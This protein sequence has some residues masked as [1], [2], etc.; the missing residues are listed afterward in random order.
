MGRRNVNDEQKQKMR[1]I[2]G[3]L[4]REPVRARLPECEWHFDARV[5]DEQL[6][7]CCYWEYARESA[8]IRA[9]VQNLNDVRAGKGGGRALDK[10][11]RDL[12]L[13]YSVGTPACLISRPEFP[14]PWLSL[15]ESERARLGENFKAEI[16]VPS[17]FPAFRVTGDYPAASWLFGEVEQ[18]DEAKRAKW[19]RLSEIDKGMANLKEANELR[20]QLAEPQPAPM[21]RGTG[22]IDSFI[23]QINWRDFTDNEIVAAFKR[24]IADIERPIGQRNKKGHKLNDWRVMLDRLAIMRLLH[25]A[26]LNEMREKFPDTWK[27]YGGVDWY[28]ERKNANRDFHR[29]FPFLSKSELPLSWST[30]GGRSR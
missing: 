16:L 24:W 7:A 23:A 3:K 21:L 13:L 28:R 5:P 8:F 12:S 11:N 20:K 17:K 29:L 9:T 14:Q 10:A 18:I 19:L 30:K 6:V 26:T 15:S 22:G 2:L 4:Q 25:H 1:R 27:L